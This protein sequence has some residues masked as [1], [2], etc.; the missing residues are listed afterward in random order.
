MK[1]LEPLEEAMLERAAAGEALDLLNE[2]PVPDPMAME[3]WGQS[4]TIRASILQYLLTESEW[5]VSG[6]GVRLRGVRIKGLLDLEAARVRCPLQLEDCYL[7]YSE[8]VVLDYAV[9]PQLALRRCRLAGISGDAL[10]ITTNLSL[11]G[12]II[13]G[14][15]VLPGTR[16][17]GAFRC[18]GARLG[19]ND[20]GN[21]LRCTAMSVRLSVYLDKVVTQGAI[22]LERADIGG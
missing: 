19:A 18:T 11:T 9:I 20:L 16:I 15:V 17:N 2:S 13:E 10:V 6:K 8:P 5:Q 7:D 12:S 3:S 22:V 4:Q 21:S 1:H 14:A